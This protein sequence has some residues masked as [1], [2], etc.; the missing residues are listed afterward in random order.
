MNGGDEKGAR[1]FIALYPDPEITTLLKKETAKLSRKY[2]LPGLRWLPGH[3]LHLTLKFL[4]RVDAAQQRNLITRLEHPD[5]A[6]RPFDIT[7]AHYDYFPNRKKARVFFLA[8]KEC[9]SL[10]G[11]A[12]EIDRISREVIPSVSAGVFRPHITLAR[13]GRRF[14]AH[15]ALPQPA[16][17]RPAPWQQKVK[18]FHLV[19]SDLSASG[20]K[21]TVVHTF[22]LPETK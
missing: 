7:A 14:N 4:G 13:L 11:L 10:L 20:A 9:P 6:G 2:P 15:H 3:H 1:L 21:Y 19:K 22:F 8:L 17:E 16:F 12:A 5:F 18:A